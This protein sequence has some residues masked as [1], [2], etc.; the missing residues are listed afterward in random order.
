MTGP[1]IGVASLVQETNTFSP[2]PTVCPQVGKQGDFR[3][4]ADTLQVKDA[5]CH[6]RAI[7]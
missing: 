1:R 7:D 5:R 3:R 6:G 4:I 2:K